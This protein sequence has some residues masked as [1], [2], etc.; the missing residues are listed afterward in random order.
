MIGLG[1]SAFE[2]AAYGSN[3]SHCFQ[4]SGLLPLNQPYTILVPAPT[5][6]MDHNAC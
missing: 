2:L 4:K 6:P 3:M 5:T 1:G